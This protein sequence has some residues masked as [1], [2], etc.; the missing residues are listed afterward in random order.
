MG[1]G[2]DFEAWYLRERPRLVRA[3]WITSGDR[4]LAAECADEAFSR[5]M[6]RWPRVSAMSSPGGWV[7]TVAFNVL[8]RSA[9]RRRLE[10][11]LLR[12]ERPHDEQPPP[13]PDIELWLAVGRLPHRQREVVALRYLAD[14]TEAEVAASLRISAGAVSASLSKA[15]RHLADVLEGDPEVMH[16]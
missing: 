2:P 5:A 14:C 15:R 13:T 11:R 8:R 7:R 1:D 12:R 3:L 6:A 10:I 16:R 9:R 4:E